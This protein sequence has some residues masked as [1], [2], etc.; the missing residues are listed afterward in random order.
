MA[1]EPLHVD[2]EALRVA[3]NGLL[4][5][6]RDIPAPPEP[7][8]VTGSDPLSQALAA[9]T[10]AVEAPLIEGLPTTKADAT[11]TAENVAKAANAYESTDQQLA[12]KINKRTFPKFDEHDQRVD[13]RPLSR[14]TPLP[15]L[16]FVWC[17]P[18]VTGFLCTQYFQDGSTYVYPSPT[19]RS[20]VV[21][22]HGP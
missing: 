4:G 5:A 19:D 11:Q 14:F 12:D 8:N 16:S 6:A 7:F 15:E 3:A 13:F 10:K 18:Q 17:V 22:Q 1:P 20:G 9:R 2:P 21:T